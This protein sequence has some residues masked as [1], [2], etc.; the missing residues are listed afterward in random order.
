[1]S[2]EQKRGKKQGT[3]WLFQYSTCPLFF[4]RLIL[5]FEILSLPSADS[6]SAANQD[7][8]SVKAEVDRAFITIGDPVQYKVTIRHDPAIRILST[9]P[10]PAEDIFKIKKIRDINEKQGEDLVEGRE[11]TLTAY[12]LGEYIL[13]PVEIQ[14]KLSD[15]GE[16]KTLQTDKI[17]ITTKSVAEGETKVDIRGLK[18]VVAL[19]G[20]FLLTLLLIALAIAG[21]L[22][23]FITRRL[24][25]P[26][27]QAVRTPETLM[28]PEEEAFLRLNQLFDS[29]LLKRGKVKEYYLKLSEILRIY[30]EK[31]FQIAAVESTTYEILRDLHKKDVPRELIEKI[32]EVLEA[33]D[34]AKFAKWKPEPPQILLINQKSKRIVEQARPKEVPSGV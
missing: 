24:F 21:I 9:V 23:F 1:M 7:K 18:S 11:F 29:D 15:R 22:G 19:K 3:G 16:T 2:C 27:A 13:D 26:A 31:R 12:K 25:R 5:F 8:I 34:L 30:F 6:F 32:S 14:Y 10:P 4:F 20:H 17:F 28:T 33:A